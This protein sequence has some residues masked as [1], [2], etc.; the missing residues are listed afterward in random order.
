M[1]NYD[2]YLKGNPNDVLLQLV[3]VTHPAFSKVYRYV[4]NAVDGVTVK[5]EN[6][7]DYWYEYSPLSIKKSKSSDDLDQSL[8]IGVGDLGLEFPLEIDRLRASTYSQQKPSLHYREYLMSDLTK[9]MLSILNLEVTD[10]QPK[11]NGAL[12]TCRAKQ[13]KPNK[14]LVML[15]ISVFGQARFTRLINSLPCVGLC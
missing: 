5:H 13:Y 14:G 12:F 1:P 6:G 4:K 11:R 10:Y 9:P 7:I 3:E 8:D 2:F 15:Q